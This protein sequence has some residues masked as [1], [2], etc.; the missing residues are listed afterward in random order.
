MTRPARPLRLAILTVMSS[1][2]ALVVGA[3]A[4]SSA[5]TKASSTLAVQVYPFNWHAVEEKA[6]DDFQSS[7]QR[8]T[9]GEADQ[10]QPRVGTAP[11]RSASVSSPQLQ[12]AVRPLVS[13]LK[14]VVRH[15]PLL[16]RTLAL[17][18]LV[19]TDRE[20]RLRLLDRASAMSRRSLLLQ[21]LVL[22][23]YVTDGNYAGTIKTIDQILRVE[24]SRSD[25]FYPILTQALAYDQTLPLFADLLNDDNPWRQ[26]YLAYAVSDSKAFGNLSKLRRKI[27]F[28]NDEFDKRLIA[29]LVAQGQIVSAAEL[30]R[31]V[32]QSHGARMSEDAA[33]WTSG[34]PP[35]DWQFANERGIRAQPTRDLSALEISI[36]SGNG[37]VLAQRLIKAPSMPLMVSVTSRISQKTQL[38]NLN[39]ILTCFGQSEPFFE[40]S[41]ATHTDRF[42]VRERPVDCSFLYVGLSG[43]SWSGASAIR[44]TIASITISANLAPPQR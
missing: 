9:L 27:D 36:Q 16:P 14:N 44:G 25:I 43:R 42:Y 12:T 3:H 30:Y 29:G 15:E 11:L 4:L 24:P 33:L 19:D 1:V 8:S 21:G 6:Y 13:E 5:S 37:G 10:S 20:Q 22:D 34:Y 28:R 40:Q 18:A 7:V 41:L 26:S 39:V 2:L 32:A 31:V 23:R 17:L 35:F 38:E